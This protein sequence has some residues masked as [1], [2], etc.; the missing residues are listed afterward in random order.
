MTTPQR[1]DDFIAY[2]EKNGVIVNVRRSR[3]KDVDGAC[4][5]LAMKRWEKTPAN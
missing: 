5:Q 3:G 4:G 1:L 2:L